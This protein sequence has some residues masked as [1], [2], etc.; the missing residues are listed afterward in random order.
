MI[1]QLPDKQK[2]ELD[3]LVQDP[4]QR[5]IIVKL[6][7]VVLLGFLALTKDQMRLFIKVLI[8]SVDELE[9]TEKNTQDYLSELFK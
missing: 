4:T 5:I 6:M 7:G 9:D 2:A 1:T 8:E 3:E